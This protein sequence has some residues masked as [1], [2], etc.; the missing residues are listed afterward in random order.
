MHESSPTRDNIEKW[1]DSNNQEDVFPPFDRAAAEQNRRNAQAENNANPEQKNI[2]LT[3]GEIE[4]IKK[5]FSE[6]FDSIQHDLDELQSKLDG[7]YSSNPYVTLK[8]ESKGYTPD[9]MEVVDMN[10]DFPPIIPEAS[11]ETSK[12]TFER[13]D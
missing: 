6:F 5:K 4:D 1:Q 12:D 2:D 8:D 11:S 3:K 10:P 7:S 13:A 9:N